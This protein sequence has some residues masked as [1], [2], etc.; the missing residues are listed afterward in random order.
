[1]AF[2]QVIQMGLNPVLHGGAGHQQAVAFLGAHRTKASRRATS[3]R[4]SR[5]AGDGGPPRRRL[6]RQAEVGDQAGI[7]LVGLRPHPFLPSHTP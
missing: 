1:M 6:L 4:S 7:D 3:A 2:F 5:S